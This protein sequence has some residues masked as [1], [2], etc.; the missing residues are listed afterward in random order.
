MNLVTSPR[1]YL[2]N[3]AARFAR[4]RRTTLRTDRD[5]CNPMP[6]DE[7]GQTTGLSK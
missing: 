4:M 1:M 3:D 7:Y 6:V 2:T 5:Q